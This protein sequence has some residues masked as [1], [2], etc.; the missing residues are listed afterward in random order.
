MTSGGTIP[1]RGLFG[2][3]LATESAGESG[4]AA[5][6]GDTGEYAADAGSK[7]SGGRRGRSRSRGSWPA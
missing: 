6:A 1:D 3:F 5:S 2:V 4:A 7:R